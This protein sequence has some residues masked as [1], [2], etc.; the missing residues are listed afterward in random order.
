LALVAALAGTAVAGPDATTSAINKKKVK[1][2]ATKQIKNLAPSLSVAHA[3]SADTA[4]NADHATNADALGGKDPSAFDTLSASD[5]R[6]NPLTLTNSSQTVLSAPI[7]LRSA[8]TVTAVASI[9]ARADGGA[10]DAI[11]C[12]LEIAGVDG[13]HQDALVGNMTVFDTTMPLTQS[14]RLGAGTHTV[15]AECSTTSG[16]EVRDRSLS[17]VATG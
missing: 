14:R 16:V 8:K 3:V 5:A 11:A 2:I 1:K 15:L 7:T 17:V 9:L 4:T 6:T 12:N 13:V 10:N